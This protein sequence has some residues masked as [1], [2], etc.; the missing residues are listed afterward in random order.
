MNA[1]I[2]K[3]DKLAEEERGSLL[4]SLKAA[5]RHLAKLLAEFE[6]SMQDA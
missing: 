5:S 2:L 6:A 4:S 1:W 3:A